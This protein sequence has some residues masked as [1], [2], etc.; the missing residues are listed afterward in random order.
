MQRGALTGERG[1]VRRP[2]AAAVID[3]AWLG[4]G[5]RDRARARVAARLLAQSQ[6]A[7]HGQAAL[8]R[9]RGRVG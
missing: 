7:V 3:H 8:G 1:G 4:L 2:V 6:L 9:G 5:N